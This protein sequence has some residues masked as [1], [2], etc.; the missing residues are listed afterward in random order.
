MTAREEHFRSLE[1]GGKLVISTQNSLGPGKLVGILN[2]RATVEYFYSP[3]RQERLLVDADSLKTF[4]PERQTRCFLFSESRDRWVAGRITHLDASDYQVDLPDGRSVYVPVSKIYLRCY[5]VADPMDTLAVQGHETAFFHLHRIG[6]LKSVLKQRAAFHGLTALASSRVEL[7]PHQ[8]EVVRRVLQDPIQRYLLADEV[9]LGKT[10]EAGVLLRQYLIDEPGGKAV[11]VAPPPLLAQWREELAD[12]FQMYDAEVIVTDI[13]GLAEAFE[14]PVG[15][16]VVD[17]A[18]N[19]GACAFSADPRARVQYHSIAKAAHSVARVLLLSAT[20]AANHEQEFLAMLHLLEPDTYRLDDLAAF[21]ER[22][23]KRQSVGRLLL[24]MH[25]NADAY[26]LERIAARVR[27]VLPNDIE[28]WQLSE[29]L[30]TS[31]STNDAQRSREIVR[32]MRAHISES[33]RIHRRM[34]RTRRDEIKD[35]LAARAPIAEDVPRVLAVADVRIYE[36]LRWIDDWRAYA[37][38]ELDLPDDSNLGPLTIGQRAAL[39]MFRLLVSCAGLS[40]EKLEQVVTL[41]L[42]GKAPPAAQLSANEVSIITNAKRFEAERE[43]LKGLLR[44]AGS[45]KEHADRADTLVNYLHKQ[46]I[47]AGLLPLPKCVVF[48]TD[49][50]VAHNLTARIKRRLNS[51]SVATVIGGQED[52]ARELARFEGQ[53]SCFVLVCD[54]A[55]EEG[56][57]LQFADQAVFFDLPWSANQIEQ[58]IGRLDRIGRTAPVTVVLFSAMGDNDSI[59]SEW[60]SLLRDQLRVFHE[61]VAG[62]Q[63]FL[64]QQAE[65]LDRRML[66]HGAEGVRAV[67]VDFATRIAAERNRLREQSALDEIDA[68]TEHVSRFY[69]KMDDVDAD[70]DEMREA[71][72]GWACQTLK[73]VRGPTPVQG[74][75]SYS[76]D[77]HS[78]VPQ[79][80]ARRYM[81]SYLRT[82]STFDRKIGLEEKGVAMIRVGNGLVEGLS[83]YIEWDDRG[84]AYAVWRHEPSWPATAQSDWMGFRLHFAVHA[85]L[86]IYRDELMESGFAPA[87]WRALQR[88]ADALFPP[89]MSVLTFNIRA[90]E[91]TDARILQILK[92]PFRKSENGGTDT[93]LH[94]ERLRILTDLVPRDDWE[95]ACKT[96]R[97]QA[98]VALCARGAFSD[99]SIAAVAEVDRVAALEISQLRARATQLGIATQGAGPAVIQQSELHRI[100]R[101]AVAKPVVRL[102]SVGFFVIAGRKPSGVET[103]RE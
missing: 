71:F 64:Q 69:K 77:N 23:N 98:E 9:G 19:I 54:R 4:K 76:I 97:R 34:L 79:S 24:A 37:V 2:G 59:V 63:F 80:I 25:E 65:D 74:V 29:E 45:P 16:F 100:L 32:H 91:E 26:A 38:A 21:R 78:L 87:S 1:N 82:R 17:E 31:L 57:N 52:F 99:R 50:P 84:S 95:W 41:R 42:N 13:D 7:Y 10:I 60:I 5:E 56:L 46:W 39:E 103:T 67:A 62:L 86:R 27:D 96:I 43:I 8:I 35:V 53:R 6:F 66:A 85:D 72:E 81:G 90:K 93:N 15:M 44:I 61:S 102:E 83:Q 73:V 75:V 28:L 18:H 22:V 47:N 101:E 20:P 30:L 49:A 11:V 12:R 33:Y 14:D 48:T 88:R 89:K 51:A 94:K 58:R 70:K 36:A 55:G 68:A 40:M 3:G 92:R